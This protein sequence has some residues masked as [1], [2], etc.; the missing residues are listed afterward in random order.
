MSQDLNVFMSVRRRDWEKE[1]QRQGRMRI[2]E[3]EN[4]CVKLISLRGAEGEKD[5]KGGYKIREN[6]GM[7]E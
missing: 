5:R 2:N 7:N 6:K 3:A 4:T 1:R